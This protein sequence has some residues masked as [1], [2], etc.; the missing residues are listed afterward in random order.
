MTV[1]VMEKTRTPAVTVTLWSREMVRYGPIRGLLS[2][3]MACRWNAAGSA[4]FT[5]RSDDRMIGKLRELGARVLVEYWADQ[6]D[7]EATLA[8]SGTVAEE[9]GSPRTGRVTGLV[10][11]VD[12]DWADIFQRTLGWVAPTQPITNQGAE[13]AYYKVSGPAETVAKDIIGKNCVRAGKP[14]VIPASA[15]RGSAI[16][17]QIRMHPIADR[18]FPAVDQAGIGLQV[19]QV[20]ST[21]QLI[22]HSQSTYA[23]TLTDVTGA[24]VEGSYA[25]HAPTLTRVIC[26]ASGKQEARIFR[27]FIDAEREA[28]WGM[29]IEEFLDCR[30]VEYPSDSFSTEI[31]A[32]AQ[33]RLDE[34]AETVGIEAKLQESARWWVGRDIRLGTTV[35]VQLGDGP[36]VS[37]LVR[38]IQVET[39]PAGVR[40][41][42]LVGP[43][44]E[45]GTAKTFRLLAAIGRRTRDLGVE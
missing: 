11:T 38:E 18:L 35:T 4:S 9:E 7:A 21:R 32:R 12:D 41:T 5:V 15:G 10:F 31:A 16:T 44:D 2:V 45:T 3:S 20:G 24:V 40:V 27:Q 17:V 28:L 23:E 1:A 22:T 43:W 33:E 8:I 13:T 19:L 37:D 42:P 25:V 36:V 39:T 34:G 6:D 29:K 26:G 14:L 30:D